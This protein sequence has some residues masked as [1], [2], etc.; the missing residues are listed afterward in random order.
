MRSYSAVPV[1]TKRLR[2][3]RYMQ[4]KMDVNTNEKSFIC[5]SCNKTFVRVVLHA[6]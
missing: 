3:L 2:E 4:C 5:A 1:V 6:M